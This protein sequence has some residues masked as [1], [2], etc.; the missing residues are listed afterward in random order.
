MIFRRPRKIPDLALKITPSSVRLHPCG[1]RRSVLR[2]RDIAELDFADRHGVAVGQQLSRDFTA[3]HEH[4]IGAVEVLDDGFARADQHQRMVAADGGRFDLQ[5][6]AGGP[7]DA[8]APRQDMRDRP[9]TV[10][11]DQ[12]CR[13]IG[14]SGGGGIGARYH[15]GRPQPLDAG[16]DAPEHIGIVAF[17][18]LQPADEKFP[19]LERAAG[20]LERR[21]ELVVLLDELLE[22]GAL[23]PSSSVR[24]LTSA[25]MD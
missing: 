12:F 3:I 6:A 4:A 21:P 22:G 19:L 11:P 1:L 24:R 15:R 10:D 5:F 7:S 8:G 14:G 2:P 9:L 18:A 20:A 16:L 13:P 23:G 17:A 25:S